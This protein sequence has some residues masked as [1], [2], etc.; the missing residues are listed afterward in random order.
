MAQQKIR[1][2]RDAYEIV[3]HAAE[4]A[5]M[6]IIEYASRMIR[7]YHQQSAH[8]PRK[9]Q[10]AAGESSPLATFAAEF[11]RLWETELIPHGFRRVTE[12]QILAG[13]KARLQGLYDYFGGN[14]DDLAT[15][16]DQIAGSPYLCGQTEKRRTP[17]D[18]RWLLDN[19]AKIWEEPAQNAVAVIPQ[20][21]QP[22]TVAD[23]AWEAARRSRE[24]YL[25]QRGDA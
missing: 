12:R 24:E 9:Q 23:L 18:L 20:Q 22:I 16:I 7:D 21:R 11:C 5:G 4:N 3:C 17:A 6:T 13:H 8:A 19:H 25:A 2:R 14:T 1:L 15:W 10:P